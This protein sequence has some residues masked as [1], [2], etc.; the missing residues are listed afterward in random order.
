MSIFTSFLGGTH[1]ENEELPTVIPEEERNSPLIDMSGCEISRIPDLPELSPLF[2]Q[3]GIDKLKETNENLLNENERLLN[4]LYNLRN[5]L[6]CNRNE[7]HNIH[8]KNERLGDEIEYLED[9]IDRMKRQETKDIDDLYLIKKENTMLKDRVYD[10]ND[11]RKFMYDI[12]QSLRKTV[13]TLQT[14]VEI[15]KTTKLNPS[16]SEESESEILTLSE[17]DD[18]Y[19]HEN[20]TSGIMYIN[21]CNQEWVDENY[22]DVIPETEEE[23]EELDL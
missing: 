1:V 18:V 13:S 15:Q 11:D 10:L 12:V 23:E 8:D 9:K 21:P 2:Q 22:Q 6:E 17:T 7:L 14:E 5:E 16:Y 19:L 3:E 4:E 20:S